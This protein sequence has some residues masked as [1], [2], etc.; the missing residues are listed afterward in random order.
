ML[1]VTLIVKHFEIV[2]LWKTLKSFTFDFTYQYRIG[3]VDV[4]VNIDD[5]QGNCLHE[6][7]PMIDP[8]RE[9]LGGIITDSDDYKDQYILDMFTDELLHELEK[10]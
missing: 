9:K 5:N 8:I 3:C 6:D 7:N 4:Y 1:P 2:N 10:K